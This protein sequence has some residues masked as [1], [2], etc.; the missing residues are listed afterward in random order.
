[1]G[2][3]CLGMVGKVTCATARSL[4]EH[5]TGASSKAV[6]RLYTFFLF[7]F[8]SLGKGAPKM[9]MVGLKCKIVSGKMCRIWKDC[10]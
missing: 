5:F 9:L 7:P 3:S 4:W 10:P 8:S 1:M 2:G 6:G